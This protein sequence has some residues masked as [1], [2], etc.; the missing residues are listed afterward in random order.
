MGRKTEKEA[1][2]LF[3]FA[4]DEGMRQSR[5]KMPFAS[6][7]AY[8][9]IEAKEPPKRLSALRPQAQWQ[10]RNHSALEAMIFSAI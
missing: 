2:R 8:R 1:V 5:R 9:L 7:V 4:W 6:R 10:K 3:F